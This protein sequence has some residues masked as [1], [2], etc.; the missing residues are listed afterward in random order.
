MA[1]FALDL[2]W[3]TASVKGKIHPPRQVGTYPARRLDCRCAVEDALMAI[4]DHAEAAG[5]STVEVTD[6]VIEVADN[7]ALRETNPGSV[8]LLLDELRRRTDN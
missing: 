1:K 7:I 2:E 8:R 4:I 3:D 6:A 5:W